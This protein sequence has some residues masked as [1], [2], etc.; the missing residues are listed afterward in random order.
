MYSNDQKNFSKFIIYAIYI[1][2][3]IKLCFQVQAYDLSSIHYAPGVNNRDVFGVFILLLL[4][5]PSS[6][7]TSSSS[8]EHGLGRLPVLDVSQLPV[9]SFSRSPSNRF[10]SKQRPHIAVPS[11]CL[12]LYFSARLQRRPIYFKQTI[13]YCTTCHVCLQ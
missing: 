6:S 10:L 1:I 4:S 13:T 5:S 7:W 2:K 8:S 12:Y 11:F 9:S 3:K